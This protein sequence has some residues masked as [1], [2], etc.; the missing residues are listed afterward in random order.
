MQIGKITK[1]LGRGIEYLVRIRFPLLALIFLTLWAPLGV[2]VLPAVLGNVVLLDTY[3]QLA[4]FTGSTAMGVVFAIAIIRLLT[5]RLATQ[6]QSFSETELPANGNRL[7]SLSQFGR[8]SWKSPQLLAT[9]VLTSFVSPLTAFYCSWQGTTVTDAAGSWTRIVH[10]NPLANWKLAISWAISGF[11]IAFGIFFLGAVFRKWMLG[12]FPNKLEYFPFEHSPLNRVPIPQAPSLLRQYVSID[13]QLAF[14]LLIIAVLYFFQ[15]RPDELGLGENW[16]SVPAYVVWLIWFG[17]VLVSGMA[18]WFDKARVPPVLI[19]ILVVVVARNFDRPNQFGVVKASHEISNIAQSWKSFV[20]ENRKLGSRNID[21][22]K[23]GKRLD[24]ARQVIEDK[25]WEAIEQRLDNVPSPPKIIRDNGR[26]ES[27]GKS[28]VV[29]TCPGGGIHAAAWAAM[30]L[31]KLDERYEGFSEAI[32][33][34]SSVS[35]GSVGTMFYTANRFL[36]SDSSDTATDSW[37]LA[38][39]SSLEDVAAGLAFEDVPSTFFPLFYLFDNNDRGTR[40]EE[41]WHRRLKPEARTWTFGSLGLK[42]QRGEMPILV[43]N[44][45][46]AA[47]GRRVLFS[48]LPTPPRRANDGRSSRPLDYRELLEDPLKQDVSM[49]SAARCSAT[50]PYV[51]PFVQPESPSRLGKTVALGDGGYVDNDGIL[52]AIGLDRLH[53]TKTQCVCTRGRKTCF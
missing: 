52:T 29:V 33:V 14:F 28:L 10:G 8:W 26:L 16:F 30:V 50:F 38:A 42:A 31:E 12:R 5:D 43:L 11:M 49:V 3:V 17:T 13:I 51:S 1:S 2:I 24:A 47:S 44:S 36:S 20:D 46:D 6:V 41:S 15:L 34:I 19:I 53:F 35:G 22:V 40:L 18:Y 9:T 45:T 21:V 37:T 32:T 48:S 7:S 4:A 25:A 27:V 23:V 39:E